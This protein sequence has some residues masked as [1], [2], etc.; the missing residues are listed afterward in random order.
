MSRPEGV[1]ELRS[2]PKLL[3]IDEALALVEANVHHLPSEEV[4]LEQAYGRYI[5]QELHAAVDLPPFASSAM[6]GYA[7]R[8]EDAPGALTVVGESSAGAPYTG[9]LGEGGAGGLSTG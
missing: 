1:A 6:D 3:S 8:A 5:A 2:R 4:A 9:E 7:L